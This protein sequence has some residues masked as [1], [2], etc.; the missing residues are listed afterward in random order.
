M[1][2]Q[3]RLLT[4]YAVRLGFLV[5][6][7]ELICKDC[8]C[9]ASEYDHRDYNKPL[10]VD[11]VCGPCNTKR[12]KGEI[13]AP[14]L[15]KKATEKIKKEKLH[16]EQNACSQM[17]KDKRIVRQSGLSALTASMLLAIYAAMDS[18][19]KSK[20]DDVYLLCEVGTRSTNF[21]IRRGYAKYNNKR[22]FFQITEAGL[23]LVQSVLRVN[24]ESQQRGATWN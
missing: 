10:D 21:L 16:A 3:A 20:F 7:N 13:F 6:P 23:S 1:N 18:S 2:R 22:Y 5:P 4:N 14:I 15:S 24:K 9:Q 19:G 8:G 12:G 11:P 17:E